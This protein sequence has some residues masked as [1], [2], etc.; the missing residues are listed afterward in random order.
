MIYDTNIIDNTVHIDIKRTT[1]VYRRFVLSFALDKFFAVVNLRE[2]KVS[3][4]E[5]LCRR[6]YDECQKLGC[7]KIVVHNSVKELQ[8]IYNTRRHMN[9]NLN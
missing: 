8:I 2:Y 6:I 1:E 3:R 4:E 5:T 7:D 9:T